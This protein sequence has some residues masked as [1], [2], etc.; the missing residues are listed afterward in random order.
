MFKYN[1]RDE[2]LFVYEFATRLTGAFD[3]KQKLNAENS[4]H[5]FIKQKKMNS[6]KSKK[7]KHLISINSLS[8]SLI[9]LITNPYTLI[10][11]TIKTRVI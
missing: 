1:S 9:A 3:D 6:K 11:L 10:I 7:I 2:Q 5:L 8:P 4:I